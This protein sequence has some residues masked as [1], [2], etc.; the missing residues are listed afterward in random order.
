MR[1]IVYSN[2]SGSKEGVYFTEDTEIDP[3]E[4]IPPDCTLAYDFD[5]ENGFPGGFPL[6]YNLER[7]R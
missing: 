5:T 2:Q 6:D 7:G 3:A 4:I 1:C